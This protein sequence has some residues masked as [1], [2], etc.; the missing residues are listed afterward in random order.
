MRR[1]LIAFS[2]V[3]AACS[4]TRVSN[5]DT[6]YEAIGV[7][8]GPVRLA[9]GD[10]AAIPGVF[11]ARPR[12]TISPSAVT[13]NSTRYGSLCE[14]DVSAAAAVSPSVI[15]LHV[16]FSERLT[17]CVAGIRAL[18]YAARVSAAPGAYDLVVVHDENKVADTVL[19]QR[20][21]IPK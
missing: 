20:V 10:T 6:T 12:S 21:Q 14:L 18:S 16:R 4:S 19:A 3:V 15:E 5:P 11:W 8:T 2:A 13:V 9:V 17:S 7:T 1:T